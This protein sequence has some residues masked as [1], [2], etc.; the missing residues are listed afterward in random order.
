MITDSMQTQLLQGMRAMRIANQNCFLPACRQ[1][2]LTFQ[3]FTVLME[4]AHSS[5]LT[6][7][8][9]SD[10]V[11]ILRTNFAAVTNKLGQR[12]L[13]GQARS[14]RDRRYT[15]IHL[16]EK[17]EA[18]VKEITQW[19]EH[20]YGSVFD[21]TTESLMEDLYR[22]FQAMEHFAVKLEQIN[23]QWDRNMFDAK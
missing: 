8:E 22:G 4:L 13:I 3:Q 15:V 14:S 9:L 20:R 10:H 6:A 16:T 2:D 19:L 18:L 11:C 5:E 17:G 23:L 21:D 12:G 1:F 7:G